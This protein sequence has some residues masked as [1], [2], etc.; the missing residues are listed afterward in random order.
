MNSMKI[1]WERG[2]MGGKDDAIEMVIDYS[3]L[4]LGMGH[5]TDME[6]TIL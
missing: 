6:L 4:G 1:A 2:G 3:S 5:A